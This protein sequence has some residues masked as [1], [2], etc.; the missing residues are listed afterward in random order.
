[1]YLARQGHGGPIG[2]NYLEKIQ[3]AIPAAV[4][5]ATLAGVEYVLM[6]SRSPSRPAASSPPPP[7][8]VEPDQAI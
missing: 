3:L 4:Y 5:G 7:S 1:V 6:A 8:Q 2:I